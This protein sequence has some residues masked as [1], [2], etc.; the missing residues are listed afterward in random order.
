MVQFSDMFVRD[1]SIE[2][3]TAELIAGVEP[4]PTAQTREQKV[5][6]EF[7][8]INRNH[9]SANALRSHSV[10]EFKEGLD[11]YKKGRAIQESVELNDDG[12]RARTSAHN[13]AYRAKVVQFAEIAVKDINGVEVFVMK[14]S[15]DYAP[16]NAVEA[17]T[18]NGVM[19]D[20]DGYDPPTAFRIAREAIAR[21]NLP[22]A[23]RIFDKLSGYSWKR[24]FADLG[25]TANVIEELADALATPDVIRSDAARDWV[26]AATS[27][28]RYFITQ[29]LK[30]GGKVDPLDITTGALG[31]IFPDR[32]VPK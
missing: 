20:F 5:A 16:S 2:K 25:E 4:T 11:F 12:I 8:S 6:A 10:T 23:K 28:V 32:V 19:S 3:E 1:G 15:L 27:D 9:P 29:L 22:L 24:A 13:A 7:D 31:V 21:R 30:T 17:A 18:L 26:E 14:V